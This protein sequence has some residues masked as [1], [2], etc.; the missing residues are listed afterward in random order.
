MSPAAIFSN[1]NSTPKTIQT[2]SI[3]VISFYLNSKNQDPRSKEK[4][5]NRIK[6]K[7]DKSNSCYRF[8]SILYHPLVYC[9]F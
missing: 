1:T 3:T 4:N 9:F 8:N 5:P 2:C 7:E 6:K